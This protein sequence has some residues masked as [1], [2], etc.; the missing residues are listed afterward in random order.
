MKSQVLHTVWCNM[1]GEATGE[2]WTWSL[3][4]MKGL[5][6]RRCTPTSFPGSF[7]SRPP[8]PDER[9]WERGWLYS[10]CMLDSFAKINSEHVCGLIPLARWSRGLETPRHDW[11]LSKRKKKPCKMKIGWTWYWRDFTLMTKS[12]SYS[13]V[14]KDGSGLVS[15]SRHFHVLP[16][17]NSFVRFCLTDEHNDWLRLT[18]M[19]S[20]KL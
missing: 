9:A 17:N 12:I 11:M 8:P 13:W 7:I 19:I 20:S 6:E 3:S 5:I 14:L 1:T 10:F 2:I 4:G 16:W 18:K 15:S